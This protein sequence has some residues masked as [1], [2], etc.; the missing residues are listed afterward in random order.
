MWSPAADTIAFSEGGVEVMRITDTANVG[1][2]TNAPAVKLEVSSATGSATPTPTEI[3]ISTT[4]NASDYSMVSPWG[5][6]S[7][8]SADTS[9]SGPKVQAAI[10]AISDTTAGGRMSM[11]FSSVV[12]GG[13]LTERMRINSGGIVGI[14]TASPDGTALLDVSSTTKGFLPPRMTT[15]QR[16]A[17]SSPPN[18]LMLYNSTTD[19]L[20]VR[21]AGA[22]V[23]LH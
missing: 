10:D 16:D 4:T 22:W 21:A 5:R 17:I 9:D 6:L 14:G 2:G 1:I 18:G 20:Q 23:D 8:Y 13:T 15:T 12:T 19:K 7:F 11:V 3:R